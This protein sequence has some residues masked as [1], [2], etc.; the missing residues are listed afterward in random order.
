MDRLTLWSDYRD[1]AEIQP[2]LTVYDTDW[3][4]GME[5]MY[6]FDEGFEAVVNGKVHYDRT[7]TYV[8]MFEKLYINNLYTDVFIYIRFTVIYCENSNS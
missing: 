4:Y 2:F 6:L 1:Y 3:H 5:F 8:S 7:V